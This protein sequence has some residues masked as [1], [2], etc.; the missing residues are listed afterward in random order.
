MCLQKSQGANTVRVYLNGVL[1]LTE[2]PSYPL[3]N[4]D[5]I[6]ISRIGQPTFQEFLVRNVCPYP[7]V[8][9]FP[10]PVSFASAIASAALEFP[11]VVKE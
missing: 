2:T 10:G 5:A 9:F 8:P 3:S 11:H 4:L 6:I 1:A 7:T